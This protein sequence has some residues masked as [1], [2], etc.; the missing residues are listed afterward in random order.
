MKE[1]VDDNKRALASKLL[2]NQMVHQIYG[3]DLENIEELGKN[4]EE[5]RFA[6]QQFNDHSNN[7]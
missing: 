6:T 5:F 2:I 1:E 7:F 4:E 3:D